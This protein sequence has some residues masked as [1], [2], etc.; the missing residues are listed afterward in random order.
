MLF[1]IYILWETIDFKINQLSS[2][3]R[4]NL[5]T[6]ALPSQI[7]VVISCLYK[8]INDLNKIVK[9]LNFDMGFV[10]ISFSFFIV[11]YGMMVTFIS[12]PCLLTG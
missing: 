11:A 3:G 4:K 5:V 9:K 10:N 2:T 1:F 7:F 12:L 8:I 6:T